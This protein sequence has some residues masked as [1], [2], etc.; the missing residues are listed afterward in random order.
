M[1]K[2]LLSFAIGLLPV[3]LDAQP[4]SN[5]QSSIDITGNNVRGRIQNGGD[6][7]TDLQSGQF[8][9]NPDPLNFSQ[10]STIFAAG[11]WLGGVDPGG[12]LKL[13]AT[14]YRS[15]NRF[16]F[17]PG[18]LG[19]DGTTINALCSVW[20]RHF[21]IQDDHVVA[22]RAALPMDAST[23]IAQHPGIAGWPG[24]GN[25]HFQDI[26]GFSL[27]FSDQSLAPFYDENND[28]IYNPLHGDYPAVLV[29]GMAPFVPSEIVWSVFND[30]NAGGV[31][32][33]S[34]GKALQMEVQLTAWTFEC[35]NEQVLNNTI[36]TAH[37]LINRASDVCD[38]T[39]VGI[40]ADIDL[41]CYLDDY[42]GCNPDLSTIFAY[43]QDAIDGQ[44][45]NSCQ[46]TPTFGDA[47]PVQTITYLNRPMDKF[48]VANGNFGGSQPP[49][50]LDPQTP[51]EYYH[52][53][54]GSWRD[55]SPLTQGGNG[56]GGTTP[57][58]H[59]FPGDPADPNAWSMCSTSLPF[60]DYR[61]V[62][63]AKIGLLEP[64]QVEE[65][66][67]AWSFHPNPVLPCGLGTAMADVQNLHNI[68]ETGFDKVCSALNTTLLPE[69]SISLAPN[70]ATD[71]VVVSYPNQLP[72]SIRVFDVQGNLVREVVAGL[73]STE[74]TISTSGL[75]AGLYTLQW[76]GKAGVVSRKLAI[77]R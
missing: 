70:P 28:G 26:H 54:T 41:G 8:I 69:T 20:D 32:S 74:T 2:L 52:Y 68:Y 43:N 10:P 62:S 57:V 30:Q 18:P 35:P 29:R 37:K 64:G 6:L 66:V 46:G 72:S 34:G 23:L 61:L 53:L 13:A 65:L 60:G 77:M 38:S 63:S 1:Q 5:S 22:F 16:D 75:P 42:V 71:Q 36:F 21:W 48:I 59:H 45:G 49:G 44:P 73:G 76:N 33:G 9:P 17:S 51:A 24:I 58:D 56:Y 50:T 7:F 12:N 47:P 19:P 31:H 11:L 3:L 27:P 14:D 4:C 40:W 39:Y 67:L 55:G 25:P 15:N